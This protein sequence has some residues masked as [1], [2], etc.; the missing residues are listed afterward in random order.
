MGWQHYYLDLFSIPILKELVKHALNCY[1]YN[2]HKII[3][4]SK[5]RTTPEISTFR[6]LPF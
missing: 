5:Q 1:I 4:S 3:A 2:N 6:F